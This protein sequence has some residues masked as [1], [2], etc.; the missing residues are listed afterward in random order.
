MWTKDGVDSLPKA[1]PESRAAGSRTRDLL[2]ASPPSHTSE[3]GPFRNDACEAV[4][5][6]SWPGQ[7]LA[8][9]HPASIFQDNLAKLVPEYLHSGFHWS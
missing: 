9:S 3:R 8:K 6:C 7:H 4:A 5:Q 1:A 2:I